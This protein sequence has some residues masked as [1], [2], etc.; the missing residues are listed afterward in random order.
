MLQLASLNNMTSICT[1]QGSKHIQVA[2]KLFL[3]MVEEK[4]GNN[5]N[6]LT[7]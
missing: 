6:L 1:F 4:G 5:A 7:I 2:Q 3:R